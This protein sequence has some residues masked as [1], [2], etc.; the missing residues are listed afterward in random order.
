MVCALGLREK[1][2]PPVFSFEFLF[3]L[4]PDLSLPEGEGLQHLL[5]VHSRLPAPRSLLGSVGSS[6]S[7]A[8]G[9]QMSLLGVKNHC[10]C[11]LSS[12]QTL[13]ALDPMLKAIVR[14]S[15]P[16][17]MGEELQ[18]IF[19]VWPVQRVAVP[20]LF[21]TLWGRGC[22]L[23]GGGPQTSATEAEHAAE[24]VPTSCVT[25]RFWSTCLPAWPAREPRG[26]SPATGFARAQR[27]P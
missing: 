1:K 14:N 7:L 10:H 9:A 8:L 2:A 23:P 27:K 18:N 5:S 17:R 15:P 13:R 20:G 21:L 16:S 4:L 22:P 6:P 12:L 19:Q 26:R 3:S 11:S 24:T 25:R